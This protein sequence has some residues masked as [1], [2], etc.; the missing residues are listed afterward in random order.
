MNNDK[1]LISSINAEAPSSEHSLPRFGNVLS[2]KSLNQTIFQLLPVCLLVTSS[3]NAFGDD[4]IHK[5]KN[6]QGNLIYQKSPCAGNAQTVSSWT[7]T[8]KGEPE[9]ADPEP[10]KESPKV[11][12]ILKQRSSGH[13]FVDGEINGKQITF[14]IDTGASVVSLP[15]FVAEAADIDCKND[16]LMDTAN[17]TVNACTAVIPEFRFG[18]FQLKDVDAI[19]APN[20][21]QPLLGMNILQHF[22]VAQESGQ[23]RISAQ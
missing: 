15:S 22:K 3:M 17:G 16:M 14:V 7:Q 12:L 18:H 8:F 21:S 1:I 23:M 9:P 10:L 13:Y 4:N 2:E 19:I 6:Q 5:C 20:L 11:E